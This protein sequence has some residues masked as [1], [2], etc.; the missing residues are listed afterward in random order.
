MRM[1]QVAALPP[2][3]L[4][5]AFPA[6]A[7][8][9]REHDLDWSWNPVV[10]LALAVAGAWYACGVRRLRGA[11]CASAP[12]RAC[13]ASATVIVF[14]ALVSPIDALGDRLFAA[15]MIQ[16]L[17]LIVVAAPLF[18]LAAPAPVLLAGL[19]RRWRLGV[20]RVWRWRPTRAA[21]DGLFHPAVV[22]TAFCGTIV[23]WHFPAP[24]RWALHDGPLH[25]VEHL[26]F[27]LSALLFWT[28]VFD[29][30]VRR[31]LNHAATLLLI[32][33][34][35]ILSDL[36]GALMLLAPRP[37]Y[38][39][40]AA[41]AAAWGLTPLQD[42]QLAGVIMWVPMSFAFI[43]A[44]IWVFLRWMKAA[45]QGALRAVRRT[46]AAT[47]MLMLLAVPCLSLEAARQAHAASPLGAQGDWRRGAALIGRLGC[48]G[49]HT[50][51]GIDNAKGRVG[52][53]LTGFGDRL[54]V[55]GMLPNTPDNLIAWIE[56][57]QRIVPGNVM[58]ILGIND[59]DA[60]DIATYLY[61]L[62]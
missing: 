13:F 62:H 6:W 52:P 22:W 61:T 8:G 60:R 41:D 36:P 25:A 12:R 18:A 27:L 34:A 30:A 45:E 35:A 19:P 37:F 49:C 11:R 58:P 40:S 38:P 48:G 15:H 53:P 39:T 17:L 5:V 44:G 59:S 10:I 4:I 54:Y 21:I 14:L 33:T 24:Y 7:H 50:I 1:T 3:A 56:N 32:V 57:P 43:G 42:Q 20:L 46:R 29:R 28:V 9:G 55:A 2:L 51:P 23:F 47:A 16:H 31:R 26:T